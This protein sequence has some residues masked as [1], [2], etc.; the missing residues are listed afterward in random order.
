ML[1]ISFITLLITVIFMTVGSKR[2]REGGPL[3]VSVNRNIHKAT[4]QQRREPEF[5][6]TGLHE[7]AG[8][9]VILF[10]VIHIGYNSK[11]LLRYIGIR[12]NNSSRS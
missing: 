10:G 7:L 9:L 5:F 3:T 8:G 12:I 2:P 11:V 1:A 4:P 6:P